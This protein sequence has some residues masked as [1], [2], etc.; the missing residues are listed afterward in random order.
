MSLRHVTMTESKE[1]LKKRKEKHRD[2]GMSKGHRN[3]LEELP[4]AKTGKF[5]K[6]NI[7]LDYNPVENKYP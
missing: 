1:V 4:M 7:M 3:Q 6:L 5:K 2:K